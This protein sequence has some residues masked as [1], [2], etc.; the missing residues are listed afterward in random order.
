MKSHLSILDLEAKP[1]VFCSVNFPTFSSICLRL[2][3]SCGDTWSISTW[4]LY[5]AIRIDWFPFFYLLTF[6]LMRTVCGK[7]S[8]SIGWFWF[9]VKYQ[10]AIG[11]CLHFWSFNYIPLIFLTVSLPFPFNLYY[12]CSVIQLEVIDSD[13]PRSSYIVDERFLYH[14]VLVIPTEFSN[15]SF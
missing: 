8:C 12:Y 10:V 13:C 6:S 4:A 2:Y 1:L 3:V 7:C 5:R 11:V 14:G 9:I 15:C